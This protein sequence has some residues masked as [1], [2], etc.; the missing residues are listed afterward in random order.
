M[1]HL[2]EIEHNWEQNL[3]LLGHL[4]VGQVKYKLYYFVHNLS[5]SWKTIHLLAKNCGQ[6]KSLSQLKII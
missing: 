1:F 3:Q 6:K 2:E 5:N 4:Q